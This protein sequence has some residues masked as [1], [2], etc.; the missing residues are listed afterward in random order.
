MRLA[1]VQSITKNI[2][3]EEIIESLITRVQAIITMRHIPKEIAT[4][5]KLDDLQFFTIIF[6]DQN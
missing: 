3:T 5:V 6:F 2:I 4:E 1:T